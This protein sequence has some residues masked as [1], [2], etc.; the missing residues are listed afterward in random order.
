[1]TRLFIEVPTESATIAVPAV[2]AVCPCCEGRGTVDNLG[3]IDTSSHDW[4]EE[5]L[6]D[7][8]AGAYDV[9]CSECNG[10]RVVLVAD[11]DNAPAEALAAY[12]AHLEGEAEYEAACRA[13]RRALGYGY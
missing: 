5:S 6:A 4:D 13:E 11:E 2:Y 1:M 3:V 9:R 7:Y 10:A 8:F 12:R